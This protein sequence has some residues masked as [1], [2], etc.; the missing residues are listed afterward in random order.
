MYGIQ[1]KSVD[2]IVQFT[3]FCN[4]YFCILYEICFSLFIV[5]RS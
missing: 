3:L 1:L 2:N 5:K 4:V